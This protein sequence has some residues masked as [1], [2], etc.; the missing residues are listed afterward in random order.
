MMGQ[1]GIAR[2]EILHHGRWLYSPLDRCYA[3]QLLP[4][5]MLALAGFPPCITHLRHA[6]YVMYR[7]K[8]KV[9]ASL[10]KHV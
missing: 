4:R 3:A 2:D 6:H 10:S 8:I 5:P 9:P 7:E 1:A